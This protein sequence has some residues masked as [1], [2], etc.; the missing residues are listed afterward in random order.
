M[1]TACS[2]RVRAAMVMAVLATA[3]ACSEGADDS[4]PAEALH[5]AR[6]ASEALAND[7]MGRLFAGLDVGGP[8][9]AV[10]ICSDMAQARSA[11]Y[12]TPELLIRRVSLASRNPANAPDLFERDQLR[13][14]TELHEA[15]ELPEEIALVGAYGGQRYLRYMKPIVLAEQCVACHGPSDQIPAEIKAVLED[16]YPDD[17]ATGYQ[18]G[19]L[20]GAFSVMLR[21]E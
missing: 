3:A 18:V 2:N 19:D 16:R 12:S 7:L 11:E 6:Q 21:L 9:R 20:R 17:R 4:I 5:E 8:A 13:R 15:G 14:L 10:E 1:G